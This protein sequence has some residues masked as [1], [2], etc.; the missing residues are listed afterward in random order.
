MQDITVRHVAAFALLLFAAAVAIVLVLR[1]RQ[2][3]AQRR[4]R[5][6]RFHVRPAERDDTTI[7]DTS[8]PPE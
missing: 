7:G 5:S 4:V 2:A 8:R 6:T 3:R 1:S